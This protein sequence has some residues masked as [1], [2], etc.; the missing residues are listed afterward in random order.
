MEILV[1]EFAQLYKG[2]TLP[3]LTIQ[4]K[5]FAHWQNRLFDGEEIQKQEEYWLS[6]FRSDIPVLDLPADFPRPR[7][8]RYEGEHYTFRVPLAGTTRLKH[9]AA[10]A[11]ATLFMVM[12]AVL[13]VLLHKLSGQEDVV[14]GAPIAGRRHTDLEKI[15]G[16]FVNTLALR[17]YP[18]GEKTFAAFLEEVK[19]NSIKAFEYQDY[20]FETLV[21]NAGVQR[22]TSRNPMFDVKLAV[23]NMEQSRADIPGLQLKPFKQDNPTTKFDLSFDVFDNSDQL[24]VVVE[25]GANLFK[26]GTVERY[27]RY[28]LRVIEAVADD[29]GQPIRH[30]EI[31]TESEKQQILEQFNSLEYVPF[32]MEATLHSIVQEQAAAAPDH[33]AVVCGNE[34]VTYAEMFHRFDHGASRRVKVGGRLCAL[35]SHVARR[36]VEG[37]DPGCRYRCHHLTQSPRPH[38]EPAPV[39]M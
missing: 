4:Y 28:F 12:L 1:G 22:D 5:D 16:M 2:D 6:R 29:P 21:E 7:M 19:D 15:I 10:D 27:S 38:I 32:P 31:I 26:A 3:P 35:E 30:I 20:P 14:I 37:H 9:V 18:I 36:A 13:N 25:Y 11:G 24:A 17:S 33:R 39:G 23:Q 34:T 8:Q